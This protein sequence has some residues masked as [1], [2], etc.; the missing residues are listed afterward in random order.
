LRLAAALVATLCAVTA[1]AAEPLRPPVFY[2]GAVSDHFNGRT[3]FNPDGEQGAG[4]ARTKSTWRLAEE[5]LRPQQRT[6][7]R[8]VPVTPSRP[9]ARVD[10]SGME[11][12]WIGHSTVL[13]QTDGLNILTDP[14]W[15]KRASPFGWI[16]PRRVRPPGVRLR[17]LPHIDLVLL[18]HD[19]YD[20]FD[21]ATLK[22]LWRRDRPLIVTGLGNDQRL[23]LLGVHAAGRDWG[24][25]TPVRPG[26]DVILDR[27]HHWSERWDDDRDRTLWT[28]FTVTLPG[29]NLFFAG[30]SGPGDMQWAAAAA[31]HGPVRLAILPIGAFKPDEEPS[32]NHIDPSQA[33]QAF[34]QLGAAFALGVHWGTFELT[35]ERIDDPPRYLAKAL[36]AEHIASSRFRTTEAGEI[37]SVPTLADSIGAQP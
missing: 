4:G 8:R 24:Q 20:H 33:V 35:S 11:V 27:V 30:D 17:D 34:E 13:I 2:Q 36:L 15:A 5:M 12:T 18:S 3:F 9:P 25:R 28:G 29:G 14:V 21:A 7:P 1:R 22:W 37:W 26:V 32:G 19:H 23:A 16:G 31:R 6:W 10:G